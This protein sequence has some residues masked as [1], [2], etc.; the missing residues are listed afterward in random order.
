MEIS[1]KNEENGLRFLKFEQLEKRLNITST[2]L[3]NCQYQKE[4]S[5]NLNSIYFYTNDECFMYII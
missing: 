1:L 3:N 2:L 4:A 5:L